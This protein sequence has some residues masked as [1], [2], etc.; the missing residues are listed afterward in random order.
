METVGIRELKEN[1]SRY[2]KSVKSGERIIITNRKKEVAVIVPRGK[3]AV[4]E[5]VL[6]LIQSGVADCHGGKSPFDPCLE[7]IRVKRRLDPF[8]FFTPAE[9]TC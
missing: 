1:L 9:F 7:L 3:E 5:E 8:M 6:Q 4:D 2:L